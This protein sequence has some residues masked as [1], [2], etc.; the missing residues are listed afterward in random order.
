[1]RQ[2]GQRPALQLGS[3]VPDELEVHRSAL[4][5]FIQHP[6]HVCRTDPALT[7][8]LAQGKQLVADQLDEVGM[9]RG[10]FIDRPDCVCLVLQHA[11]DRAGDQ[12]VGLLLSEEAHLLV[13]RGLEELG[14]RGLH[15]LKLATGGA[16]GENEIQPLAA[17][18]AAQHLGQRPAQGLAGFFLLEGIELVK[19]QEQVVVRQ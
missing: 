5:H 14:I 2:A 17:H 7:G 13:E 15:V 16:D 3:L 10:D 11:F 9:P 19:G 1:M 8:P 12:A 18:Q 4:D 6:T